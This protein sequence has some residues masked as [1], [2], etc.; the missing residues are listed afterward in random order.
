MAARKIVQT[1][2]LAFAML[3][4]VTAASAAPVTYVLSTPGVV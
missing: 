1:A 3:L 4:F 2:L